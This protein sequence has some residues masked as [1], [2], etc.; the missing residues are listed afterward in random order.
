[1]TLAIHIVERLPYVEGILNYLAPMAEKPM[2]LAYE[3]PPGVPCS[4]GVS[5]PHTMPIHDVRPV[6][7][8]LSTW[9]PAHS[10]AGGI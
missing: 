5:E 10:R 3:P 1:M 8:H 6:A 2:N 9:R 4:N 7:G